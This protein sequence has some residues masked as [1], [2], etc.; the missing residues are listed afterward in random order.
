MRDAPAA[1]D[2]AAPAVHEHMFLH[3]PFRLAGPL[4]P[5]NTESSRVTG[6]TS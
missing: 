5:T 1:A 4:D 2:R 6:Y 3:L